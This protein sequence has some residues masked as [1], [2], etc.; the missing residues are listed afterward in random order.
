MVS[1]AGPIRDLLFFYPFTQEA[2]SSLASFSSQE[3]P[4]RFSNLLRPHTF[5]PAP[6]LPLL[7]NNQ[8]AAPCHR[9]L[10]M[11][12]VKA[13]PRTPG[14]TCLGSLGILLFTQLSNRLYHTSFNIF[15]FSWEGHLAYL[16]HQEA[17]D[18]SLFIFT[19][20]I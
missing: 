18:T 8:A 19:L 20:I 10:Q 16:I 17:S 13:P 4:D 11:S 6:L 2:L 12:A 5:S 1:A 15:M 7:D 14:F 3:A 9:T